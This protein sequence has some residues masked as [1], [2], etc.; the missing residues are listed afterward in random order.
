M[1]ERNA[2]ALA[3]AAASGATVVLVTGRPHRRV[4]DL[5]R[6]LPCHPLVLCGNGALVYD[7][8]AGQVVDAHPID[9]ATAAQVVA[10]LRA[11]LPDATFAVEH[12]GG[13]GHEPDYPLGFEVPAGT[14]V[15]LAEQ[16]VT[17][18]PTKLL[19]RGPRPSTST[20]G[21]RATSA[22]GDAEALYRLARAAVGE[23]AELSMSATDGLVEVAARGVTKAFALARLADDLGVGPEEV[24]AFGD[25]RNDIPMLEWAGLGI[26][27][28]NAPFDVKAAADEVTLRFDEDGVAAVLERLFPPGDGAPADAPAGPGTAGAASA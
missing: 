14:V 23:L 18:G 9:P 7:A 16:L 28:A 26:A 2:A 24:V 17:V 27:M 6:A 3:R 5:A 10:R 20:R 8:D 1:S 22:W 15:G 25:M 21:G 19:A 11:A 12:V 13:F 4:D